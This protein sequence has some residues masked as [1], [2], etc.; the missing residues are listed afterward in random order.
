MDIKKSSLVLIISAGLAFRLY[1]LGAQSVWFDEVCTSFASNNPFPVGL[2]AAMGSVLQN[3]YYYFMAVWMMIFG[4]GEFSIRFPSLV[5]SVLSIF[6]IFKLSK[7]LFDETTGLIA[8]LL[9]SVSPYSI[10]Y[11]QEAR[12]YSM[13]WLLGILSFLFFYRFLV[14]D[15]I[16]YLVLYIIFSVLSVYTAYTAFLFIIVQNTIFFTFLNRTKCRQWLTGQAVILL[17]YSPWSLALIRAVK[18]RQGIGWIG[19]TKDYYG[20]LVYAFDLF[21]NGSFGTKTPLEPGVYW[22]LIIS[23]F[24]GIVYAFKQRHRFVLSYCIVGLWILIPVVV[25]CLVDALVYPV[26]QQRY[27][28]FA[29]IPLVII[30]SAGMMRCRTPIRIFIL[31]LLLLVAFAHVV[32][33]Y[34]DNLKIHG[35]DLRGLSAELQKKVGSGDLIVS[36]FNPAIMRYYYKKQK[37]SYITSLKNISSNDN[38]VFLIWRSNKPK[39]RN[40][41]GYKVEEAIDLRG[42]GLLKLKK[43]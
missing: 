30:F 13:L 29:H 35:E 33:Y 18:F 32:P 22:F 43:Y 17:L 10:N 5:F 11:A 3:L 36:N 1:H 41:V 15:R 24:I 40:L 6:F 21:F 31:V 28:G 25:Y 42:V 20:F 19:K 12:M 4:I 2:K 27:L 16:I 34:Q 7:E 8:A 9:L 23:A 37:I 26:L 39:E 38:F 14:R